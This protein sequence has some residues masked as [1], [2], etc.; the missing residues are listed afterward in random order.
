MAGKGRSAQRF[1]GRVPCGDANLDGTVEAGDLN[2]LA[3]TWQ[4]DSHNWTNGNFTGGGTN[5]ADLNELALNWQQSV[6][7]A[8]QA[9]PEPASM[10]LALLAIAGFALRTRTDASVG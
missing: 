6:P 10:C 3:L 2:A 7:A 5:A 9:V 1:F 4:S 8:A